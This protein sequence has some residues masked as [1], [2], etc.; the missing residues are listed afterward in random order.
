MLSLFESNCID[1][2]IRSGGCQS[3]RLQ[4]TQAEGYTP[5]AI[6]QSHLRMVPGINKTKEPYKINGQC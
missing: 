4:I 5:L 1:A 6:F 2:T 3:M